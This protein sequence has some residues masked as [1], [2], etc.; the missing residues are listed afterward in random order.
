MILLKINYTAGEKAEN[1]SLQFQPTVP[2]FCR[3]DNRAGL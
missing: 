2:I 1:V 3:Y